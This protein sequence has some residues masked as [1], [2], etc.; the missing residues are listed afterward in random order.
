M[1]YI[2]DF[3]QNLSGR[4]T[5]TD[6]ET[7]LSEA[8]QAVR[9]DPNLAAGYQVLSFGLSATRRLSGA[10][11]GGTKGR[12]TQSE[13]PGQPDGAGKGAGPVRQL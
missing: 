2:V 11:Q 3:V 13:R 9:L 4:A 12:R 5:T 10:M 8:R 6:V 7:G 1:T